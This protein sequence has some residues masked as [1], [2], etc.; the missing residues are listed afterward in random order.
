MGFL[1]F[2]PRQLAVLIALKKK[3]LE[4]PFLHLV[5]GDI[6]NSVF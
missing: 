6:Y 2:L 1:V 5:F 3:N 4:I